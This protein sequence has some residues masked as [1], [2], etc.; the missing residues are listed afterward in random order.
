MRPQEYT[1][2]KTVVLQGLCIRKHLLENG[3]KARSRRWT[4]FWCLLIESQDTVE[5]VMHPYLSATKATDFDQSTPG[6][7]DEHRKISAHSESFIVLHSVSTALRPM[8]YSVK[9]AYVFSL[10]LAHNSTFLFQVNNHQILDEWVRC[11][12]F[13]AARR[14]KD[15]LRD[16]LS[17]A[18]YGWNQMEWIFKKSLMDKTEVDYSQLLQQKDRVKLADWEPPII[19]YS[20]MMSSL[21][22]VCYFKTLNL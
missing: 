17:S 20:R 11:L 15:P 16:V 4:K 7:L 12:N 18:D 5:L 22:Q 13:C 14:S 21:S 3:Q 2:G 9:R 10:S 8:S 19:N 1:N 6:D